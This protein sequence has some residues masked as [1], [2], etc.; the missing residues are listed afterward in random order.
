MYGD[1]ELPE[2]AVQHLLGAQKKVE[3]MLRKL[4]KKYKALFPAKLPSSVPPDRNLGDAH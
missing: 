3:P 4:F 2:G 1:T